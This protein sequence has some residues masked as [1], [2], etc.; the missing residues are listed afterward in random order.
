[1]KRIGPQWILSINNNNIFAC[2][3]RK[4]VSL[5]ASFLTKDLKLKVI[6]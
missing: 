4:A 1:M 2:T 5:D 6:G 3:T